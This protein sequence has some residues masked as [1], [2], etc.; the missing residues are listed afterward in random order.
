MTIDDILSE[1]R[2]SGQSERFT[3]WLGFVMNWECVFGHD[4]KTIVCENV[5]GDAGGLTFAGIDQT[6]H[7][8]FP[9]EN[10]HPF[11]VVAVYL[12]DAWKP[13]RAEEIGFPAGEIT[14]NFAVNMGLHPAVIFLQEAID[15]QAHVNVDGKIG[16]ETVST[17][18]RCSGTMLAN[19]MEHLADARYRRIADATP[20]DRKFLAGWLNRDAAIDRWWKSLA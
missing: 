14:A 17:A 3:R 20:R 15:N 6:S 12:A 2:A 7:P 11:D 8:H 5:A 19:D 1:S 18:Q 9:F 16:D 13:L 10:P 4:G